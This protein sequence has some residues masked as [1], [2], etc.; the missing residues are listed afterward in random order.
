ME[1]EEWKGVKRKSRKEISGSLLF[2]GDCETLCWSMKKPGIGEAS[3]G[4]LAGAVVGAI[5]GLF[6]ADIARAIIGREPALLFST[7]K[8]SLL[9]W[10]VSWAAGWLIGGQIGPRLGEKFGSQRIEIVGG[11][12]GGLIPVALIA[13]WGWYMTMG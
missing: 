5:G 6:A 9:C 3:Q 13:L 4:A 2:A 12:L 7:P 1:V 8:L 10:V 11:C